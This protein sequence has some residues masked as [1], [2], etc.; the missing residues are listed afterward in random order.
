MGFSPHLASRSPISQPPYGGL[1]RCLLSV[2]VR[3][4]TFPTRKV[5][6]RWL[7]SFWELAVLV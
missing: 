6:K 2:S 5:K 1:K 3:E 4:E 7:Y